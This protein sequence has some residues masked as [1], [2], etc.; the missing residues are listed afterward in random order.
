MS[1]RDNMIKENFIYEEKGEEHP[2]YDMSHVRSKQ[3]LSSI[4]T[5]S[6]PDLY[7][8]CWLGFL[9]LEKIDIGLPFFE[10]RKNHVVFQTYL[11]LT[12]I[13]INNIRYDLLEPVKKG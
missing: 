10:F 8:F 6:P 12:Q 13:K 7:F 9:K 5:K 4:V 3:L 2:I 11:N 1:K